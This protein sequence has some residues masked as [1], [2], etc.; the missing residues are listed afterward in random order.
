MKYEEY[1]ELFNQIKLSKTNLELLKR[2]KDSEIN[3]NINEL[4]I[5][6]YRD[7]ITY[8]YSESVANIKKELNIIFSDINYLDLTLVTFK[9]EI[10]Y[11]KELININILPL[12]NQKE[13]RNTIQE[14]TNK[15]YE[16]LIKEA[17]KEDPT[18]TLALT[19][20]NN[21]IKWSDNNEL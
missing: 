6:K 13:L 2:L 16:I 11:I 15:T 3:P 14:E 9:K 20:K 7:L 10:N 19:I 17:N 4:L 8:K 21:E 5:P 18:G 1:L 12:E